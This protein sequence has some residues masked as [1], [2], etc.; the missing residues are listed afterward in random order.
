MCVCIGT[1]EDNTRN[2]HIDLTLRAKVCFIEIRSLL[3]SN[4]F[5]SRVWRPVGRRTKQKNV[6]D[7][8]K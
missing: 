7:A 2:V 8:K 1:T 3:F 5:T 6:F 4:N